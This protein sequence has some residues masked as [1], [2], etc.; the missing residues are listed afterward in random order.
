MTRTGSKAFANAV[1]IARHHFASAL[2]SPEARALAQ[3]VFERLERPSDDGK[4]QATRYPA[5]EWL[6]AALEPLYVDA[7]Y[8]DLAQA[9]DGLDGALGWQRRTTGLNGSPDYIHRHVHG[10]LCGPGG[11]ESRYDVQLGFTIMLPHTRYPDHSHPPEEAYVLLSSG[12]F[13]QDD[14]DW[15][16]PG[17]G[18]GIHNAPNAKHAMRSGPEPFFAMWCLLV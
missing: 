14:G 13:R 3:T 11:A 10:I 2:L 8:H 16:D 9:L 18:C 1:D 17:I 15:V 7:R 4:R 5:C 12:E 6:G